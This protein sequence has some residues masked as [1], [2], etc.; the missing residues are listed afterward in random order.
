MK[1]RKVLFAMKKAAEADIDLYE[2]D[3]ILKYF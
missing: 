1:T 2:Q 3:G